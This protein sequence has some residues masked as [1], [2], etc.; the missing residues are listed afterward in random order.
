[1]PFIA[2]GNRFVKS[3]KLQLRTLLW[4]ELPEDE[5]DGGLKELGIPGFR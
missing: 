1:M 3:Q 5:E 2:T 4:A